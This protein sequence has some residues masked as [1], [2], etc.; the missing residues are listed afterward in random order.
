MKNSWTRRDFMKAGAITSAGFMV[1]AGIAPKVSASPNEKIT[2]GGIA[3]GG[4]GGGDIANASQW[5]KIVA[6][7]DI[8]M[9]T[10]DSGLAHY[11]VKKGYTDFRQM[12]EEQGDSIDAVTVGGPDHMHAP[13]ALMA[14]RM[15]KHVYAQKPMSRTVYETQMMAKVAREKNLCTQMGNQGSADTSLRRAAALLK[16]GVIG[17]VK[18]IHVWTDRAQMA[19]PVSG[20]WLQAIPRPS[21]EQFC[22][23]MRKNFPSDA[24]RR[25]EEFK[26]SST[27]Q[28]ER[29]DWKSWLC[30]APDR[31]FYPRAY[32]PVLWRGW[33][34]FGSGALG[35]M[36]CHF[37]NMP[38]VGLDL[39]NL[40]SIV[41]RTTGH[42]FDSLPLSSEIRYTF[43]EYRRP[44]GTVRAP[45]TMIWY[46]GGWAPPVELL[47]EYKMSTNPVDTNGRLII[48]EK[49]YMIW[50]SFQGVDEQSFPQIEIRETKAA[51]IGS[52]PAH[53][54]EWGEAI[55][56]NRPQDCWSSFQGVGG[57]V[58]ELILAGNFAVWTA[59]EGKDWG[60]TI[61]FTPKMTLANRLKTPGAD[62]LYKPQ[63]P[64]GYRLD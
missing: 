40:S 64:A 4:K 21:F 31:E 52:D 24:E 13:A 45:L 53:S 30:V 48:G 56:N 7:A 2:I 6:L 20:G 11:K 43:P 41:A 35:D 46:D 51:E 9:N 61:H 39:C 22:D 25:I 19:W 15:G 5:G 14:M 29:I 3:L 58:S 1:A 59:S 49:G 10:L 23:D 57:K 37:I 16:K 8:D 32:H 12:L 38:Y 60:E 42:N 26:V 54:F 18:E 36:G 27:K 44:D 34:D 63:Y 62:T 17:Q 33:W 50:D 55:R 28:L 47:R